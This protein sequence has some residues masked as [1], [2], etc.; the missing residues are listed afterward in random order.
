MEDSYLAAGEAD[1]ELASAITGLDGDSGDCG[2]H[3]GN[4]GDGLELHFDKKRGNYE[5][6]ILFVVTFVY[7]MFLMCYGTK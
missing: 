5:E 2:G 4:S 3:G 7:K 1:A 6:I